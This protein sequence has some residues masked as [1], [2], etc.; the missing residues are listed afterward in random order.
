MKNA[1]PIVYPSRG[2][3]PSPAAYDE[4]QIPVAPFWVRN[5]KSGRPRLSLPLRDSKSLFEFVQQSRTNR[6]S[7]ARSF[8]GIRFADFRG[9]MPAPAGFEKDIEVTGEG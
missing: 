9:L 1:Y 4:K 7:P 5:F 3:S 2:T 6:G 8:H